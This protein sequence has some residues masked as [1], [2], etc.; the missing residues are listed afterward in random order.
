[1]P[2]GVSEKNVILSLPKPS[3]PVKKS[4]YHHGDL[5]T[6]IID[7]VAQLIG[8]NKGLGFH[9]KDVAKLVGTSQPAIYKHFEGK[10]ALL[11][12]TA[13]KGYQLQKQFRDHAIS[14]SGG[15]PL[16]KL[17]AIGH[18]YVHFSR[19]HS[20]YFLLM[21][22]LETEEILSSKRYVAE[23]NSVLA[24]VSGLIQERLGR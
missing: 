18:A 9:L 22:N 12:E 10:K 11:V 24:L 1:M 15:S 14:R 2:I 19:A 3:K 4:G 21:K 16:A 13:V 20:G 5:R 17:L 6:S 23:Q 7:A 8:E